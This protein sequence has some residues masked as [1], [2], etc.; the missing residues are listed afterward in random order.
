MDTSF[1]PPSRGILTECVRS[2][3]RAPSLH[4]SQ[5]WLFRIRRSSIEVHADLT[6]G[7]GVIDPEGRE[8]LISVGAAVFTLRVALRRAGYDTVE[9]LWPEPGDPTLAARVNLTRVV[10]VD[11]PTVA[12]AAAIPYRHT[13]R[14]P[15]AQ[16]SVSADMLGQLRDAARREGAVLIAIAPAGRDTV[17]DLAWGADRW[18]RDQPEYRREL[19][20]YTDSR[21]R[22]DGVPV[23]AAGPCDALEVV[24][25][26]DFAAASPLHRHA[27]PFEP[28][29]A[30][31]V[32]ATGYDAPI[33]WLRAGQAL[34]RVLLTATWLGLATMPI[35]QPVEVPAV[36]K[37]L[38]TRVAGLFPQI[39]LRVG[40]GRS[41]MAGGS[42]RRSLSE[43]LMKTG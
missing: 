24:P 37:A 17:L 10:P 4:N 27:E 34:Q 19:D 12:L 9:E 30:I 23:W 11:A 28:Y 42:P 2:A 6:R 22:H 16:V 31:M 43:V 7:L 3:V 8:L 41:Q 13:N 18:L 38:A 25:V 32:L 21:L 33:D 35:S 5:P 29:P 39:V 26:R 1:V 40:Y 36:R 14:W 20:R 15:F